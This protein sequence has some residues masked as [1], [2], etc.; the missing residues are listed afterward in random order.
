MWPP[1]AGKRPTS[2][3][4]K[5]LWGNLN[6]ESGDKLWQ[7]YWGLG[8]QTNPRCFA[9][10][11]QMRCRLDWVRKTRLDQ[12]FIGIGSTIW[13]WLQFRQQRKI[14][15]FDPYPLALNPECVRMFSLF[16]SMKLEHCW[17]ERLNLGVRWTIFHATF[18]H[19]STQS[20][21]AVRKLR[22]RASYPFASKCAKRTSEV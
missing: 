4:L 22:Q 13:L 12:E 10:G 2:E 5:S 16:L 18:V 15:N 17:S 20:F 11:P 1:L 9:P 6:R 7:T 19:H 21:A 14:H 3:R 8:F